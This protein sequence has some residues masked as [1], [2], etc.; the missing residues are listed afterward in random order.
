MVK[1]IRTN[2]IGF[3]ESVSGSDDW[4]WGSDYTNGDLY[5]AEEL[6]DDGHAIKMNRLILVRKSDG[7]VYEPV[8][9]KGGQYFGKPVFSE[10]KLVILLADF[11]QAVIRL[12]SFLPDTEKLDTLVTIPRTELENCY[13]LM[14]QLSPLTLTRQAGGRFQVIWP[15]KADFEIGVTESFCFRDGERL[16]FSKWFEDPD[17]REE[18]VVRDLLSGEILEQYPGN[19]AEIAGGQFWV[20]I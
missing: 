18:T 7:K 4:L 14:P 17:Y 11:P 19:A 2:G 3:L 12:L 5:E 10:G 9:A 13:N 20:L 1:K 6:Y 16:Y 15:E 8:T